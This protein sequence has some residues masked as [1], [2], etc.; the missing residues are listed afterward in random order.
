MFDDQ[1]RRIGA[2]LFD[3]AE[4]AV[5]GV[6]QRA[7]GAR[8]SILG[9][10]PAALFSVAAWGEPPSPA[11]FVPLSA[12]IVRV[13]VNRLHGG[14]S[15]G[16]G[17]TI[18]PSV[19]VT[20]CHVTRDA[21][22]IRISGSGRRWDVDGQYADTAHDLCFLRAP[23]WHGSPVVLGGSRG[24]RSGQEVAALGF[25]GGTAIMMRF[26]HIRALHALEDAR[27]IES[28][29]AF[30]SGAS[31][32]GLFDTNGVLIGLLTFRL[33]GSG[34]TYYSVP[35]QW[36]RDRVPAEHQWTDVQPLHGALAFWQGDTERLPYFM[37]VAR[38]DAEERWGELLDL[39]D[40]WSSAHPQ[41]AEPLLVRAKALQKLNRPQAAAVSFNDALGACLCVNR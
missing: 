37:R 16:S 14:L 6:R 24:L 2:R 29:A 23:A 17:V 38:L 12:S 35:V 18:A 10:L 28:D 8:N 21:A 40:H 33:R 26:G 5:D 9:L 36:I 11:T 25:A 30:T 32:G 15:I 39:A 7:N 31:G 20:N 1:Y 19:V 3:L 13:E 4:A 22:A 41:D 27:I 34:A